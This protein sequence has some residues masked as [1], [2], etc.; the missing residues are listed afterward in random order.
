MKDTA[1]RASVTVSR[2]KSRVRRIGPLDAYHGVG[3]LA[4]VTAL[5]EAVALRAVKGD[6]AQPRRQIL[7][8]LTQR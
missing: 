4:V 2:R 6:D 1:Y 7:A 3:R 8:L 5:V